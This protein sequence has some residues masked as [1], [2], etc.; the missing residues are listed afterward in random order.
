MIHHR[1]FHD[2]G[3]ITFFRKYQVKPIKVDKELAV[4]L[5]LESQERVNNTNG[6]FRETPKTSTNL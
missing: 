1:E 5:R 3:A 2:I 4:K 6:D